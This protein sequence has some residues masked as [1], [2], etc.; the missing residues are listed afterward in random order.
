M[1]AN[2]A[3]RFFFSFNFEI[4]INFIAKTHKLRF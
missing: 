2:T 4:E 3:S 1:K